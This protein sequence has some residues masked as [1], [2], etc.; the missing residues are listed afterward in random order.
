MT[1]TLEA[2]LTLPTTILIV[3][4]HPDDIEFGSGGSAAAWTAQGANVIYCIVTDGAGGSNS[5]DMTPERLVEIRR[6]EQTAAAAKSGVKEVHFLGYRDGELVATVDLRR[7]LTRLIRQ[8]RPDRV[9]IMDPT[10]VLI[11]GEGFDYINHPDHR[12][13]G[14]A[15][16]YAVFPSAGSRLVMPELLDEGLEPHN[17]KELYLV[18]S[19]KPNIAVDITDVWD[20]KVEALLE[21]RSQVDEN[22][23]DEIRAWATESGKEAGVELAE[24]Y[25]VMRFG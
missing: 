22:V 17:V 16:L 13:A 18:M 15:A 14:E 24:A 23:A 8:I 9:V 7:H 21:H 2:P 19:D 6:Q 3:V 5:P 20:Q 1:L 10:A 4:A 12:A 11:S 25:R